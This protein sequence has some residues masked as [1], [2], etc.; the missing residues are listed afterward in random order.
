MKIVKDSI[1]IA[2][3]EEMS[4]KM[5]DDLVKAVVDVE[6]KI[7]AV[8]APYHA[9]LHQLLM[10]EENSEPKDLWGINMFIGS[11]VFL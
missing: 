11:R 7:M 5:R 1:I 2:E 4:K 10:D 3:L 9:D 6:K 8:D